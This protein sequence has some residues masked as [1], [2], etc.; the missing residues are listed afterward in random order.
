MKTIRPATPEDIPAMMALF[1]NSKQIMRGNGNML[2]WAG[3]YPDVAQVTDDMRRGG[4][5]L[6][7]E[8]GALVGTFAFFLG[9]DPT[10]GYIEGDWLDDEIPYGT[11]HRL[12]CAP[13]AHG[14]AEAC[15]DWCDS[16]APSLRANTHADNLIVQHILEKL[17]FAFCGIIYVA[18]GTP[19][20][21]Y[22][23]L[24]PRHVNVNLR[25]WV[26]QAILPRYDCFDA[27]HRRNHALRVIEESLR[28]GE[29]YG[30][31]PNMLYAIAALHDVGLAEGR[32]SH[33]LA[34]ARFIRE[35]QRLLDWFS[36]RQIETM[37]DAAEDHRA[38]SNHQPRSIYG[39]VVAEADR[40]IEPLTIIR[41]TI[42]YGLGHYPEMNKDEHWQ[43]TLQHLHEKY[44]KG[45]YL[46]LWIPQSRNALN[47]AKL[48]ALIA[49]ETKLRETFDAMYEDER[50]E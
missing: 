26:E 11:V 3:S 44:A 13:G 32:E 33:H 27:A 16:H 20:K 48:R 14:I 24:L 12:A 46:S 35:E 10:Y 41:R 38:S 34:S 15:F 50:A 39:C 40:D 23:R 2:Q 22:Q 17:G 43:R 25:N 21:A 37:A 9:K 4:S 42:Q 29:F 1:A 49:N 5:F 8:D 36:H 28:L 19:R 30:L 31:N 45:G 7:V 6:I 47:L 18:D